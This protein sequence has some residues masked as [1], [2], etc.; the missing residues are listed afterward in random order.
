MEEAVQLEEMTSMTE[1]AV[2]STKEE[3][4][5][6]EEVEEVEVIEVVASEEVETSTQMKTLETKIFLQKR[7]K[8]TSTWMTP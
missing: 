1:A 6:A 3:V 7:K 5:V 8:N 2:D 4:A